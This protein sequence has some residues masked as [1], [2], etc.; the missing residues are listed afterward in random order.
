MFLYTIY[1]NEGSSHPKSK[2]GKNDDLYEG[3]D[4]K[5]RLTPFKPASKW[6]ASKPD[7]LRNHKWEKMRK[8]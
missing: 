1:F 3:R 7:L 6:S 2:K 5:E 8:V 4:P